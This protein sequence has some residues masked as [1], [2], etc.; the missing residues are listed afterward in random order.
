MKP[1]I[2][3]LDMECTPKLSVHWGMRDQNI[4]Y[5]D[6]VK[7]WNFICAQ[8]A[9]NDSK[10]INTVSI[11]DDTKRFR[12]NPNDDYHVVK[13]IREVIEDAD[14]VVGHNVRSFDIKNITAKLIEHKLPPIKDVIIV[15]TLQLARMHNFTSRK[16]D[17]LAKKL[18]LE[19]K[20]EHDKF[21]FM[22]ALFGDEKAI[23]DIIRYGKGDIAPLRDLYHRLLPH[24]KNRVPNL[25]LFRSKQVQGCP[26]CASLDF[27]EDGFRYTKMGAKKRLCCK[28]CGY[29][30]TDKRTEFQVRYR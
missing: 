5:Q 11:L 14:I 20:L 9:W 22:K 4:G 17:A 18:S 8:W 19:R 24:S 3:F 30:F 1:E 13:E 12:K 21:V 10:K 23:M 6:I 2:L 16:L 28:E 15:D 7:D 27:I 26:C 25:N 29:K